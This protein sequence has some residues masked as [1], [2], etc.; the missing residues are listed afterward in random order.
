MKIITVK[1][2][3][4][5][6]IPI[7]LIVGLIVFYLS[8]TISLGSY[9]LSSSTITIS[10]RHYDEHGGVEFYPKTLNFTEKKILYDEL[11]EKH[12]LFKYKSNGYDMLP[13]LPITE[14]EIYFSMKEEVGKVITILEDG[15]ITSGYTTYFSLDS[16][17]LLYIIQ[18]IYRQI[19]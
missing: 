13:Y 5:L 8:K 2:I 10:K 1:K 18:N 3:L 14:Y 11:K 15:T 16:S 6:A 9:V 19:K 7:F 17:H 4:K 12:L